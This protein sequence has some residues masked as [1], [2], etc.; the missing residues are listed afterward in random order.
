MGGRE[1]HKERE[2]DRGDREARVLKEYGWASYF[3]EHN[4]QAKRWPTQTTEEIEKC[5]QGL[6]LSLISATLGMTVFKSITSK[7]KDDQHKQHDLLWEARQGKRNYYRFNYY[8][9]SQ[10]A[11][12]KTIITKTRKR[13]RDR[14]RERDKR[15]SHRR[16]RKKETS[17]QRATERNS[18]PERETQRE[19][20]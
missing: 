13:E 8:T 5:D 4:Q 2:R 1:T 10:R 20:E 9:I 12:I 17:Q 3:Q 6:R 14:N 16:K 11:R 18:E 7:Q 15:E 19:R